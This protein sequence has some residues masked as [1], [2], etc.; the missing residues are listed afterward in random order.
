MSPRRLLYFLV[1]LVFP[2]LAQGQSLRPLLTSIEAHN[3]Q[4]QTTRQSNSAAAA[5]LRSANTLGETSVEYSPFYQHGASGIASSELIVSQQFDFPTLYSARSREGHSQQ[6]VLDLEYQ[7]LRRD[8]L[9]QATCLA[10]DLWF[11]QQNRQLLEARLSVADSL[12]SAFELRL[13][14]GDATLIDLN[15]IRMDRMAL[16]T[17]CL[18]CDM[19]RTSLLQQLQLLNGGLEVTSLV[20]WDQCPEPLG[21]GADAALPSL[22]TTLAQAGLDASTQTLRVAQQGWTPN[23]TLGY[24]RDTE[25][26]QASNGFLVGVSLPLFSN[27]SKVKAARLRHSAAQLELAQVEVEQQNRQQQLSQ[28]VLSLST[29]LGL[30][31]LPLMEQTLTLLRHAVLSGQLPVSDYYLEADR[32]Y[33]LQQERLTV[34]N[35]YLKSLASLHR[36]RL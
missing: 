7:T 10:Y 27:G 32:I 8:I 17:E 1:S 26:S 6:Q 13:R 23:L 34:E 9:L 22:E 31:D 33:S 11:T 25:F 4:L 2:V 35:D 30:Y 20:Q 15:R 12:L 14:Q 29:L 18:R 16:T 19:Q 24:R 3:A 21:T 5:E 28:Q 36:D